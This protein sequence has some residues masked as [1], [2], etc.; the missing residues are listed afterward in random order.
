[1]TKHPTIFMKPRMKKIFLLL[2]IF[3]AGFWIVGSL[4]NVYH[5]T[6]TGVLFEIIWL[7]V[8]VLTISLP[9]MSFISWINEGFNI[10]SHYLLSI[11]IIAASVVITQFII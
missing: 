7:P 3:V 6:I 5:F 10:K 2:S 4:I 9:I 8:L 1:M 11:I